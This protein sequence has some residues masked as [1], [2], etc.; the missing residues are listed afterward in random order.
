MK[1][2]V[3]ALVLSTLALPALA[4]QNYNPS[5]SYSEQEALRNAQAQHQ[6][7]IDQSIRR[8]IERRKAKPRRAATRSANCGKSYW[9][10]R[11]A[12]N[13]CPPATAMKVRQDGEVF[14]YCDCE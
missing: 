1:S 12:L 13:Y 14:F 3:F 5:P 6:Y 4:E 11:E 8:E 2:F 10:K 9:T 7:Y